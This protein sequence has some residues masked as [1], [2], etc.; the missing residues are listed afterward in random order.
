LEKRGPDGNKGSQNQEESM[1]QDKDS[2]GQVVTTRTHL[3]LA[4]ITE[5]RKRG[6]VKETETAYVTGDLLVAENVTSSARRILGKVNEILKLN[7]NKRV[8]LG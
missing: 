7:E 2:R 8:L 3:K 6:L 4:Q 1:L 5:L